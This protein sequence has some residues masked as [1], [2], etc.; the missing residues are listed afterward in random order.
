[1]TDLFE[2]VEEQ[3]RSDRYR[4]LA[5]QVLPWALGVAAVALAGALG[6]WG[7]D[8]YQRDMIARASDQHAAAIDA[9]AAGDRAKARELWTDVSKSSAGGYKALALMHLGAGALDDKKPDEAVKLFDAAAVAAP[10]PIVGD[11]ARLKSALAL[12]DTAPLKDMEGRLTPLMEEGRPYRIQAREALAIAKLRA[13]DL[14]GARGDF[15]LISQSLDASDSARARADAAKNLIDTGSAK[16]LAGVVKAAAALPPPM[17]IDP[18]SA[19]PQQPQASGP[20]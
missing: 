18:A 8:S 19:S 9:F 11:A 10:D 13:G 7:W 1:M 15:T 4:R 5:R 6:Y 12:L 17:M 14:A 3:L 2:E 16:A 20:Q